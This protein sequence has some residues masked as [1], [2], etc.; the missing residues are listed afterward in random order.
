VV[1]S[2]IKDVAREAQVSV[3]AVSLYLNNKPGLSE[4]TRERIRLVVERLGYVPR[5]QKAEINGSRG[6]IGLLVEKL[7]LPVFS[8]LFYA[9]VVQ[10]IESRAR[11]LG[12]HTVLAVMDPTE[13]S[14]I[15]RV[16]SERQV[17][18][19]IALGG[20]DLT[21]QLIVSLAEYQLPVVLVDNYLLEP[22]VDCV[23]PDNEMGAY[24]ATQHLLAQGHR[25]I[26]I[27]MG[28]S[29]YKSLTDR[30]Q[31]YV[32]A[33]MEAGLASCTDLMQPS[34]SQGT[35]NKGYREAQALLQR[36]ERPTAIFCI[37]DRT[38]FGALAAVKEARLQVP[39]DIA[40]VGFDNVRDSEYTNP[41]LTTVQVPKQELGLV[42]MERL[43]DLINGQPMNT[44]PMK[45]VLPTRLVVRESSCLS[46]SARNATAD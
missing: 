27:I 38:A 33:M 2:T 21:D 22:V 18:G 9:E 44:L 37:S 35:P 46:L 45:L 28:P 30:L 14:G 11:Q 40:L 23:L 10:G 3:A 15:P 34:L 8:D 7:P 26:A 16:V 6:L 13:N 12:Y 19:L 39:R 43:I 36:P 41:P 5:R 4:Q 20:G 29:K 25:R 32:R 1:N 17:E 31:G 42:A 24:A